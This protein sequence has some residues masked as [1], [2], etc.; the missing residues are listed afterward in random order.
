ML[1]R[2]PPKGS[3]ISR[4]FLQMAS[5]SH[6]PSARLRHQEEGSSVGAS[7]QMSHGPKRD[8]AE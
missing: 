6:A 1:G 5:D 3:L 4:L 2:M 8:E 7:A